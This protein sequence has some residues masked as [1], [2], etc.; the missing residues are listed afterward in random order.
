MSIVILSNVRH[1]FGGP[2]LLDGV[3][4]RIEPRERI[5]FIGR[6]GT[7]KSTLLDLIAGI[8]APDEGTVHTSPGCKVA[9]LPQHF[10]PDVA[11]SVWSVVEGALGEVGELLARFHALASDA[12]SETATD[13]LGALQGRID[14]LNGWDVDRRV[15]EVLTRLKLEGDAAYASLSGGV[16]RRV[17]LARAL[18][19]D[20]DLLLLDEPTNHLD[21]ATID[22]LEELLSSFGGAV[23]FTTHDLRFLARLATRIVELDRG[24]LTSWPGDYQNYL[25]RLDERLQA[26]ETANARFDKRLAGEEVWI[27]QG[28]KARRTRN[29]GRAR[30]LVEMRRERAARRMQAGKARI[31]AQGAEASGKQVIEARDIHFAY[32]DEPIVDGFSTLIMRGDRVGVI[33]ANGAGKTTLLH[34]L[35]GK[36]QPDSGAVLHGTRLQTAYFDQHR[37]GL[38]L[39]ASVQDNVA[40]GDDK[41][42]INGQPRHVISYLADF[43]FTGARA[44]SPVSSLSGGER[45][46]LLLARLFAK[47]SNLLVMDEPTNDLDVETLELVEDMLSRYEGTLLLV[48]HDR[49]FLD[50]VVT[51][52]IAVE[53]SGRVREYVGGYEDWL[54]QRQVDAPSPKKAVKT[55]RPDRTNTNGDRAQDTSRR[56]SYKETRELDTLPAT[57]E[58]LEADVSKRQAQ[59]VSPEFYRQ[60][61]EA[62]ATFNADLER[63]QTELARLYDRWSELE[64]RV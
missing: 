2:M 14:A 44:R 50:N 12:S 5:G 60:S 8:H 23:M 58:S 53:G 52:T 46:R 38:N 17:L 39:D 28:I 36:L 41:V 56:L 63:A 16:Q 22:W 61:G 43:L 51:S 11:G 3:D 59:M 19:S 6:N 33:G 4:I 57:I 54:R 13:Q 31:A 48:S 42:V 30:R 62:I 29:E 35:L 45:N 34:L 37:E 32:A 40:D 20:P 64:A 27:R 21:L 15:S 7:G 10:P 9:L 18:V 26:E 55:A 24:A 49:A 25:R 1:S 47:P